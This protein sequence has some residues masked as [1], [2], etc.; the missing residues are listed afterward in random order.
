MPFIIPKLLRCIQQVRNGCR[1]LISVRSTVTERS[2]ILNHPP[3]P[4]SSGWPSITSAPVTVEQANPCYPY[5]THP[6]HYP[7]DPSHPNY[8]PPGQGPHGAVHV[9]PGGDPTLS[10]GPLVAPAN[11]CS[12]ACCFYQPSMAAPQFYGEADSGR[13]VR[14]SWLV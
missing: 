3:I 8:Y 7:M 10:A 2:R 4:S 13:Q 5:P 12:D 9:P 1:N 6:H 11:V 14:G